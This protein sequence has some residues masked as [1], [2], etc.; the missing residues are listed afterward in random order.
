MT[1]FRDFWQEA[2][3]EVYQLRFQ[4]P[5]NPKREPE[6]PEVLAGRGKRARQ[7]ANKAVKLAALEEQI[8][9]LQAG[10]TTFSTSSCSKGDK[11]GKASGKSRGP[12]VTPRPALGDPS[13]F[14]QS[15]YEP[16]FPGTRT[17]GE[18]PVGTILQSHPGD[19]SKGAKWSTSAGIQ[20]R[21]TGSS[22]VI[23]VEME[24]GEIIKR[25][26]TEAHPFSALLDLDNFR[27]R[28]VACQ[29]FQTRPSSESASAHL[30]IRRRVPKRSGPSL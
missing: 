26:G 29:G 14:L 25:F 5:V 2:T 8:R 13:S 10:A 17:P 20:A 21:R 18:R 24:P 9:Q 3:M 30:S 4:V 28:I 23:Q 16:L 15:W 6:I 1:E 22:E 7:N 19:W 11:G 12:S 27:K